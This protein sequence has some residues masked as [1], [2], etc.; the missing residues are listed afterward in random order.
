MI[1]ASRDIW[2]AGSATKARGAVRPL[3]QVLFLA[4][5]LPSNP[6]SAPFPAIEASHSDLQ[7]A[8]SSTKPCLSPA[9]EPAWQQHLPRAKQC[10]HAQSSGEKYHVILTQEDSRI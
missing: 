6:A 2:A 4:P 7:R 10:R 3:S 8:D 5:W 9:G 1:M